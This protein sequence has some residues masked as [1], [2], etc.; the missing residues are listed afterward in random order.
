VP[1]IVSL[2]SYR[3]R[4]RSATLCIETLLRQTVRPDRLILW[5][6]HD[7]DVA[8]VAARLRRLEKRGLEVRRCDDWRSFKKIVPTILE[9]PEA[10]V[11][12]ADD[13]VFYPRDWLEKLL[14]A[15]ENEQNVIHCHRSHVI[16]FGDDGRPLPYLDWSSGNVCAGVASL[17]VFPTGVGGVLYPPRSL[18]SRVVDHETFMELCSRSD[19]I[20][21][22]AMSLLA[23]SRCRQTKDF[24]DG[25]VEVPH[26]QTESLWH[27]NVEGGGNDEQL[28]RVFCH[29][30]LLNRFR[31]GPVAAGS[32]PTTT[33]W[34]PRYAS[35]RSAQNLART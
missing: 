13:D 19:D 2:T 21:L 15:Y 33:S 24:P 27:T 14:N 5:L 16:A 23:N 7:E 34:S 4:L 17:L 29:F 18:D 12:T 3:P 22:K 9:H 32:T 30:D 26:S 11:V 8:M 35:G 10:V 28:Q 20:W 6:A 31:N 25:F 1:V